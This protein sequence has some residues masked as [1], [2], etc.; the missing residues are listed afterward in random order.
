MSADRLFRREMLRRCCG[1]GLLAAIPAVPDASLVSLWEHLEGGHQKPTPPN[2]MGPFYKKRAPRRTKLREPGD[3]TLPL[4]VSGR[5]CNT[6]GEPLPQAVIQIWHADGRGHY[7]IEGYRYRAELLPSAAGAYQ[8]ETVMPGHYPDRVAQHVHYLVTAPGC[9][10]LITQLYFATD[11]AF[12]GDPD[13]NF[14]KDPLVEDRELIRPVTL[15]TRDSLA[16]AAVQFDLCL[17]GK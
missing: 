9:K 4:L 15:L 1:S 7:D 16:Q 8:F 11:P 13:R 10:P 2:Q 3:P 12:E 17:E 14:R 5:V 6:D